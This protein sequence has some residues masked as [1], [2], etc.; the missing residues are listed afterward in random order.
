MKPLPL[1]LAEVRAIVLRSQG[2]ADRES[3]FGLGKAAVLEAIQHLGYIQVDAVSVIQRAHHHVLWSRVPNYQPEMLHELQSP[4]AAVFEYWNHAASYL[5]MAD[6][7]FSLPLMRKHRHE[8]HWSDDTPELR[9]SMRRLVTMIRKDGA[10]KLSDVPSAGSTSGWFNAA[11]SKI[12]RRALHELWMRGDI[13]IRSRRGVEKIFDLPSRI[14]P[15]GIERALPS[16]REAAE[17]HLLR[18]LR[19]LGVAA[20][21]ELN[22]LKDAGSGGESRI[23]LA[24]LLK[25]NKVI[26]VQVADFAKLRLFAL[27]E[28]L[29]L[30]ASL[31]KQIVRFLSPFDNLT[32]QRRRLKWLFDFDYTVEIYVPPEK[33]KYGYFV[34]PILWGDS[35]IGRMDVKALRAERQLIIHRLIFEPSF[36]D[37]NVAKSSFAEALMHFARFQQCDGWKITRVEPKG[38]Q[39]S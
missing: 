10:L 32:I 35:L 12:E 23:A 33:R 7:R 28:A 39:I 21:Q 24:K 25:L 17:F 22:Y 5:P 38:Y 9:K 37:W 19:A 15:P 29:E 34:L 8:F 27:P 18:N 16:K 36:R 2:L 3:P 20:V 26:E 14:L 6:F 4:D 1:S 13:M 11:P 31:P 30:K